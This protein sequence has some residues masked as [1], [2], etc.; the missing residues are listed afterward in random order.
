[1]ASTARSCISTGA[2]DRLFLPRFDAALGVC[3]HDLDVGD[4][5]VEVAPRD[6][7]PF[8]RVLPLHFVG[9]ATRRFGR[10]LD[11]GGKFVVSRRPPRAPLFLASPV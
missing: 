2:S 3:S 5:E 8:G 1:M 11:A 6:R 7:A 10:K 9:H 4:G